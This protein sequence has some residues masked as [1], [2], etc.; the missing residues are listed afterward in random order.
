LLAGD[1]ELQEAI[2]RQLARVSRE[3]S[4]GPRRR[5]GAVVLGEL[6]DRRRKLLDLY[7]A[8][9]IDAELFAEGGANHERDRGTP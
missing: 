3:A 6:A 7:Y 2:R 1:E 4:G 9:T 8:G 5:R